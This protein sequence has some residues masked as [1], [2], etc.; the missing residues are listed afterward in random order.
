MRH[1]TPALAV[2][3]LRLR[4]SRGA[5]EV[6]VA[7]AGCAAAFVNGP[8]D[9]ALA[10]AAVAGGEHALDAGRV[11]ALVRLEVA[12]RIT[13]HAQL[14][15][16]LQFG[17][18]EPERQQDEIG[19]PVPLGAGQVGSPPVLVMVSGYSRMMFAL[20]LPTRQGPDLIAGHWEL[21]QAMGG[22]PAQLVWDNEAAVGSWR[23]GWPTA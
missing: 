15:G 3:P 4:Q 16:Q 11:P 18:E 5:H 14:L 12:T 7:F 8:D 9:Q 13:R 20:M 2:K 19:L 1:N 17:A 10:A 6:A 21:L 22:V 23:A